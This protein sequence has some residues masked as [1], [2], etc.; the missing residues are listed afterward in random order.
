MAEKILENSD[1]RFYVDTH[2]INCSLCSESVPSVFAT[3]HDEGYEYV[4]R[5]PVS[6]DEFK[7]MA[8]MICLC[9]ASAIQ[10]NG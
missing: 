5:Q 10:D 4:T 7:L 1:G 3:N 6:D 9:P 8:E 2:C